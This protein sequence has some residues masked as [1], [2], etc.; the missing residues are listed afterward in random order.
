M[1]IKGVQTVEKLSTLILLFA[2]GKIYTYILS[3]LDLAQNHIYRLGTLPYFLYLTPL[4]QPLSNKPYLFR[5]KIMSLMLESQA[6][7]PRTAKKARWWTETSMNVRATYKLTKKKK[8]SLTKCAFAALGCKQALQR[9]KKRNQSRRE[10]SHG[11]TTFF[12]L[13]P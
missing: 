10:E 1:S 9:T 3:L 11:K 5:D 4:P 2:P 6:S 7:E 8:L 13:V 12:L